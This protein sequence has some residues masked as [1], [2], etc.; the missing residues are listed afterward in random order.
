MRLAALLAEREPFQMVSVRFELDDT[1][2]VGFLGGIIDQDRRST[3]K[4]LHDRLAQ[5]AGFTSVDSQKVI[6]GDGG[7]TIRSPAAS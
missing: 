3:A 2:R 5:V 4:V 1:N 6:A 7:T